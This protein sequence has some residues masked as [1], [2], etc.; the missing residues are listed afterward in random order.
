MHQTS[1]PLAVR[2]PHTTHRSAFTI[3]SSLRK[4]EVGPLISGLQSN[5]KWMATNDGN[6]SV[7]IQDPILMWFS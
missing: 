3:L 4:V 1:G 7:N 2:Q 5:L 6:L